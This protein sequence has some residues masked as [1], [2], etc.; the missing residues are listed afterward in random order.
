VVGGGD[1][2]SNNLEEPN[3]DSVNIIS[4][5]DLVH[6]V[7]NSLRNEVGLFKQISGGKLDALKK[8]IHTL[9]QLFP[10]DRR[11]L[12]LFLIKFNQWLLPHEQLDVC[13][14]NYEFS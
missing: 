5:E 4:T 10:A 8:Y 12:M 2:V 6:A 7:R 9:T 3:T 1:Q 14:T 11:E 13:I